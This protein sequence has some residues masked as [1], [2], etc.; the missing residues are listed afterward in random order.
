RLRRSER[1]GGVIVEGGSGAPVQASTQELV[2]SLRHAH[3]K[4]S[5][6][7][8]DS[9]GK[10]PQIRGSMVIERHGVLVATSPTQK[11]W[12]DSNVALARFVAAFQPGQAPLFSF[13][14]ELDD[15]VARQEGPRL[16]DY[17]LAVAE[18]DAMHADVILP[19]FPRLQEALAEGN[20]TAWREWDRVKDYLRFYSKQ[21]GQ[22]AEPWADIG[23]VAENYGDA[24][25][26]MNL[27]ARH[28][29]PFDVLRPGE[30][31]AQRLSH[32][33][34]VIMFSRPAEQTARELQAFSSK[35]GTVVFVNLHG[36]FPW[37]N[38][39]STKMSYGK[40]YK[41]GRGE[42]AEFSG[43]VEDPE[44]FAQTIRHLLS[45]QDVLVRLWNA[46]TTLGFAYPGPQAR[47][48]TLDLVNYAQEPLGVQVRVKGTFSNIRY[49]TPE[50]GFYPEIRPEHQDGFTQF[51]VHQLVIGGRVYLS[52]QDR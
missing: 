43:P 7:E 31:T 27:L 40:S 41:V 24:Y 32:L 23:V 45:E 20:K 25:E 39:P 12:I 49:E 44:E 16:E 30:V 26:A 1:S 15:P 33:Q 47:S 3:Q 42:V 8:L 5:V 29:I 36:P 51:V 9:G 21:P 37:D 4:L 35:G 46:L 48:L 13:S 22:A 14:W 50:H 2:E 6:L 28:N 10:Q 52:S 18:A 34:M 38:L 19:V 17:S 11:P